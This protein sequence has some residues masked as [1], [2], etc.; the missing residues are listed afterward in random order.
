MNKLLEAITEEDLK[1]L[2]NHL[3]QSAKSEIT[4]QLKEFYILSSHDFSEIMSEI[5][6]EI[7]DDIKKEIKEESGDEIKQSILNS[8]KET[9]GD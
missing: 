3:M 7:K 4:K 8:F 6:K 5:L 9:I 2:K 1:G